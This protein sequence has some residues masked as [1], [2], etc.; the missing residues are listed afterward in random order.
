MLKKIFLIIIS[1]F[2][3]SAC[4]KTTKEEK[5][6]K[7]YVAYLQ[8]NDTT[9][10]DLPFNIEINIDKII[11]SEVMYRVTID[12][13]K[14]PLRNIEALIIHDNYTSGIF[15]DK[16][17]LIP[18]VVNKESNYVEGIIL[19]GYIPFDKEINEF[20]GTFKLLFKYTDDDDIKHTIIYSTKK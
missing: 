20:S 14:I 11:D 13:P 1:I 10:V 8:N 7:D 5:L 19:A 15:D 18:N 4:T 16:Y 17:S 2:I 12:N 9:L 3:L 6:Y